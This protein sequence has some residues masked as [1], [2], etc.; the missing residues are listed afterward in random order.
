MQTCTNAFKIR[1]ILSFLSLLF[2]SV[3]FTHSRHRPASEDL[4]S[5]DASPPQHLGVVLLVLMMLVLV[6]VLLPRV[7]T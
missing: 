4:V 5:G 7:G 6:L 3:F 2:L 1:R